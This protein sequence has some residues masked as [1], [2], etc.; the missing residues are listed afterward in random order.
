MALKEYKLPNGVLYVNE[1]SVIEHIT[2]N[3]VPIAIPPKK[4]YMAGDMRG[5]PLAEY[6]ACPDIWE[7]KLEVHRAIEKKE[8]A[9]VAIDASRV[10]KFGDQIMLTVIPKAYKESWGA[11]VKV[12]MVVPKNYKEVWTHNPHVNKVITRLDEQNEYDKVVDVTSLGLKFRRKEGDNCADAIL[13]GMGLTLIN[14]TPVYIVTE[15]EKEWAKKELEK[16]RRGLPADKGLIGI[17]LYSS[18]KSR[19]YPKM[20]EVARRLRNEGYGLIIFDAK[21]TEGNYM[22]TFRQMAALVNIC[23]LIITPDSA[24]L[25]LAG[26]LKKRVISIFAYTE[27]YVYTECYEKADFIQARCP[28]GKEPCWWKIEC[29]PGQNDY[30]AKADLDYAH[31]LKELEPEA[32]LRAVEASFAVPKRLL[33]VML[34]YNALDM[35]KRAVESIRSYHDYDLFVVDNKSTDGTQEWLKKHGV[36][37]VS[38]KTSVAAAQNIGVER[39]KEGEH[40]YLVFLN[41]DIIL[42]YDALNALVDCAIKS[43]A[44]G[45][46]CTETQL[47]WKVDS[48]KPE[49]AGWDEIIDIP[50]GSYSATLFTRECVEKVGFFNERFKPRYIEDNDYTIRIRA[51]GGRFVRSRDAI[52]WHYLGAV[53]KI[54]EADKKRQHSKAWIDNINIFQ[55]LYGF[56]PHEVQHLEKL[57]LEWKKDK[58]IKD[59]DGSRKIRIQRRM[60]GYGDILF[61][62]VIARELKRKYGNEVS[63]EYAIPEQFF[64]VLENNPN[65]NMLISHTLHSDSDFC[66]DITDL[67]FRVELQEMREF[68]TIRSARTE[69][70]LDIFGLPKDNLKPD[71]FVTDREKSWAEE[72]WNHWAKLAGALGKKKRIIYV[73]RGS[74]KL[75]H[76]VHMQDLATRLWT[77]GYGVMALDKEN[78]DTEWVFRQAAALV[79]VA[80]LVISPDSGI[81]NL[82][83]ALDVPVVTIFSNRNG[84]NFAKMFNSMKVVQGECPDK[85]EN[86]CDFFCPCFG[87]G[88]HRDKENISVPNCLRGL[89]VEKVYQA[90][91]EALDEKW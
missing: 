46:M 84:K 10:D 2:D 88:A 73:H 25:H 82:A 40:D 32:V 11:K 29:I 62:S 85:K 36:D 44:W 5:V 16:G 34:T 90:V 89:K 18:V 80:D 75:K 26:A 42:R 14:K 21:D 3:G 78:G 12:D 37:Y 20:S 91:K 33:L 68:G 13:N 63:A 38:R 64:P 17:S 70:Y 22:W 4:S 24:L 65:I 48:M 51:S 6:F 59:L 8:K 15:K 57:G 53:V 50:A 72:A 23:D 87:G 7:A 76:W 28:Y 81:S 79:S 52:F 74:N 55:E 45:V 58:L 49:G 30:Q 47:S 19:T 86:Y 71:Y 61:S 77:E 31:C 35:T 83:G 1:G 60:G 39:F 66:A 41:N 54:V 56:H 9:V 67:E 43:K 69:I 27:G